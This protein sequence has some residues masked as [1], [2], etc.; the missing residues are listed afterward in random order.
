MN[1]FTEFPLSSVL[2]TNLLRNNF[3]EPT[4]VQAQS[5][6]PQLEGRD[7][8]VTASTGTGKTVAFVLPILEQILREPQ[9][10]Q[11][12]KTIQA[13]I[14]SP[15]RELAMQ[16]DQTL[17]LL[18][19][20][21][22]LRSAVVCGGINEQKQLQAIRRGVQIVIAT[23]GRLVD[24]LN[25]KLVRL[26]S[27][28][29]LVLDEADRM[30]DMGFLP[31]IKQ[32]MASLPSERQTMFFSATMEAS[33]AQL[34]KSYL[35]DPVRISVGSTTKPGEHVDLHLYE[36]EHERKLGLLQK[37]LNEEEGSFLV[38]ARTKHG[39]DKLAKKLVGA[40]AKAQRIHGD[41][42]QAQ[43]N[44][45]LS[46]FQRGEYRVLVATDVAARGIHVDGIAHVVNFDLPQAPEDFIHRVGRTGRA[47][48]RGVASTFALKQERSEIGR[49]EKV[50]GMKL[51]RRAVTAD[52]V[53][54]KKV[55]F[56]GPPAAAHKAPAHKSGM[57]PKEFGQQKSFGEKPKWQRGFKKQA[58]GN[59]RARFAK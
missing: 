10:P 21:T 27:A 26:G 18:T 12:S 46:G 24:F 32:I 44:Q 15:T 40:G 51:Q 47:G 56:D 9:T 52:V 34:I 23:P 36:V 11:S 45:A 1:T 28:R 2:Q 35:K 20:G 13:L 7:V 29:F 49:I 38:F 25:R 8:V 19:A 31:P 4:P 37:M 41:R 57:G 5:I 48:A 30:L 39:A 43:R 53:A 16:I 22:D 50:L 33:A 59:K 14:L 54:E 58:A 42:T 17:Q 6:G 55:A 3:K